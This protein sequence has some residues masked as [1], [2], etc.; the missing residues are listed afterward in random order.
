[1]RV[2]IHFDRD[3]VVWFSQPI[4]NDPYGIILPPKFYEGLPR[5]PEL[6]FPTSIQE[7]TSFKEIL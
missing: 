7:W 4:Y 2:V 3:K 1:M 5:S 6:S